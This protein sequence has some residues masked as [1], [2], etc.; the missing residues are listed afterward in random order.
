MNLLLR[1]IGYSNY[2]QSIWSICPP[3]I[4]KKRTKAGPTTKGLYKKKKNTSLAQQQK[5]DLSYRSQLPA[6]DQLLD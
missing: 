4:K 2:P 6:C 3:F 5:A 1:K